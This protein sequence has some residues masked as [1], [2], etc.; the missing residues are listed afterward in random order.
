MKKTF[1]LVIQFLFTGMILFA[2]ENKNI[3]DALD[4]ASKDIIEVYKQ[5][6]NK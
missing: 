3:E 2:A 6:E 4:A 1:F 5:N